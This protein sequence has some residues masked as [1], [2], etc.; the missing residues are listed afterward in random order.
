[1]NAS[2][3]F[4]VKSFFDF[5]RL[6]IGTIQ[7]PYETYRSIALKPDSRHIVF[8]A[9][10]VSL[11]L[12]SATLVRGGLRTSPLFLTA[13]VVKVSL[14]VVMSY[15]FVV[16]T[17]SLLRV[18]FGGIKGEIGQLMVLWAYTLIP[19]VCWFLAMSVFYYL[20]PP[21][22]TPSVFGQI[23]SAFFIGLSLAILFWKMILYY[24]TLRFGLRLDMQRIVAASFIFFPM[25]SF[26]ALVMYV[27]GIFRVPFL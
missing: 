13:S 11:Y 24:L 17:I 26:F 21:P 18:A 19:T 7:T 2:R 5:L 10:F 8:I 23:A 9:S 15:S 1:M 27:A 25:I 4:W 3:L 6:T 22:R 12:V 20:L 16:V 14:G